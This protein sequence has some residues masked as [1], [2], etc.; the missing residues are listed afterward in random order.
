ML[1]THLGFPL[2]F[3]NWIMCCITIVSFSVL[4]NGFASNFFHA[5]RGLRQGCPLSRLLFLLVMEGLSRL[6]ATAK[7]EGRLQ[8]LNITDQCILTH[9][10]F[11]DDVLIFLNG[12]IW[13]TTVFYDILLLFSMATG[14][15]PNR[16][17][18]TITLS[19]CTPQEARIAQ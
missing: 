4:I 16:L 15:E 8:G 17:K 7:R 2:P 19:T 6:I 1:L 14:M 9:L 12:G 10:L 11:V 18:S 5:K 13:D 3:I